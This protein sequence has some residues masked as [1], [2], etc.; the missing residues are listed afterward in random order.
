MKS[1]PVKDYQL[2]LG[3][4]LLGITL[5]IMLFFTLSRGISI[6]INMDNRLQ[7]S[8]PQFLLG[9]D[10]LGRD[11]LS[12]LI[13]GA[14]ISLLTGACVVLI[15]AITG[16]LLGMAAGLAGGLTDII[17]MRIVDIVLAFPGILLALALVTFFRQGLLTLII[18]LS[19][20][21]SVSYARLIRGEVLK[22]KQ[23]EFILAARGYNASFWRILFF[24]LLPFILPL[25]VVQASIDISAVILAESGLNF[26]GFGLDPQIPTLG[27]LIDAGRAHLFDK[28][29]LI[30][31]PG[32]VLFAFILAFNFIGEG[33]RKKLTR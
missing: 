23:K 20:S 14:G 33:L 24:H 12:C 26:L 7:P 19:I 8:S 1:R 3:I 9:T 29:Y 28:P 21:S 2:P 5:I 25:V 15:S 13:Y 4:G 30:I 6:E 16:T 17:F 18:V 27:Q 22:Y 10:D 32:V 11:L 31:L